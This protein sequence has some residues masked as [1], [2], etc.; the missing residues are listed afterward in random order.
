MS[1]R[2]KVVLI[3]L[4]IVVLLSLFSL[5]DQ[6]PSTNDKLDKWEEEI[7]DKDNELDPL[8]NNVGKSGFVINIASTIENIITKFFSLVLGFFEGL[9]DKIFIY[10]I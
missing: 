5:F 9:L 2:S 1:S 8:G 4:G 7:I 10:I 3:I 6:Q